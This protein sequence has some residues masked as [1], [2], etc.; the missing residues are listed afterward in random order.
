MSTA[1]LAVLYNLALLGTPVTDDNLINS[2]AVS[3]QTAATPVV[4][5]LYRIIGTAPS[6]GTANSSCVL[7]SIIT[8]EASALTFVVND[9]SVTIKV[10]CAPGETIGGVS[11]G[12]LAIPTGQSGIF[13]RVPNSI[14]GTGDWRAAVIP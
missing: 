13:V 11:N 14:G 6:Q 12:S 5:E 1:N 3:T 8:G 9:S 10:F 7:K 2:A 4:G